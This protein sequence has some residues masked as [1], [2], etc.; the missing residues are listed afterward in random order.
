MRHRIMQGRVRATLV[1]GAAAAFVGCDPKTALL[2]AVDPDIID[3]SSVQSATGAVAVRNGA[4][5]RLRAATADDESTWLFGGLLADEWATSSTFVQNDETDQRQ[6]KLDNGTVQGELRALYRVRT[7]ANQAIDLLNKYRPNPVSD[8]AE[9]YFARGFAELQLASDFCNGIPLTDGSG[10]AIIYGKPLTVKEVFTVAIA[11]FDS[12]ITIASGTDNASVT[13]NRAARIGKAR[14]LLGIG[15]DKAADAAAAVAGI[16]TTF[17]YDV[18]ASLT[19]GNNILWSQPAGSNRYTVSDS[20]QGNNRSILVKNATP[21]LSAKDPRVPA[22]YKIASNGKDTVKSQDGNT[23]VIQVDSLWGQTS[24]V[25]VVH[26]LDARLIEAEAALKAGNPAQMM[27]ILNTLRSSPLQIT[28]PSPT[29]SGTHPGWTTPVMAALTDPGTQDGRVQLLFREKAFWQFGR[30]HRLG[31]LRRLIRDYGRAA[32]G[33][34]TFPIGTHYKGG[35]FGPDLNL[36]VT[37]DEQVGNP[38]FSGC[39]D[40]KA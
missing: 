32:D 15:L 28:A 33:S 38:S 18:T 17:R 11:S 26:G 1:L 5:Q 20:L 16:P 24:A 25:A 21:F 40:R 3:P 37:S 31:D 14:A 23:Y 9:M 34:D 29:A 8:V 13:I 19:G 12:A 35:S 6:T 36:P 27:T 7:S 4:L 10:D 22:H 39:I 30:G 2:E